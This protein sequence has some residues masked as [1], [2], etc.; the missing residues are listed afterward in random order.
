[1]KIVGVVD[2]DFLIVVSKREMA[3]AYPGKRVFL[4]GIWPLPLP[5]V[6]TKEDTSRDYHVREHAYRNVIE[7]LGD[8]SQKA[9]DNNLSAHAVVSDI[10]K[11]IL[12]EID[13]PTM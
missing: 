12:F 2:E 6:V 10:R 3:A 9:R 7:M 11:R 4:G 8:F 1:M 13:F 5:Q